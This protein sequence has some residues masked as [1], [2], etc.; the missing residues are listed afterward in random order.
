VAK[1][2][3]GIEQMKAGQTVDMAEAMA[4]LRVHRVPRCHADSIVLTQGQMSPRPTTPDRA[5]PIRVFLGLVPF[6]LLAGACLAAAL[7]PRP[8]PVDTTAGEAIFQQRCAQCHGTGA[9]RKQGPGL[10][11]VVGRRAAAVP[12][13][14]YTSALAASRLTWD[15]ATLD[16][17]LAGPSQLVPGTMMPMAVP[18]AQERRHLIDYLAS[19]P[20]LASVAKTAAAAPSSGRPSAGDYHGDAPGVRRHIRLDDLPPPYATPSAANG[21]SVVDQP[22]G[23]HPSVPPGFAIDVFARDLSHPR[24]LR[25]APDGDLFVAESMAGQ[26][27]VLRTEEGSTKPEQVEVFASGLDR[28]FGIAFFPPGPSPSWIYVANTNAV[29]RFPY[30]RGDLRARGKPQTIVPK[31]T[32]EP[33]GHWTRDIAFSRDGARMFVS[34]G[35]ASN[36]AENLPQLFPTDIAVW[37][38]AHG[39]GAAWDYE[40]NRADVLVFDPEGRGGHTF[41]TGIRNCV[42]LAVNPDTGE[43]WCSVDERDELGDDLVPDYITH[44]REGAFYGWPWFYLGDHED[45]RHINERPDLPG[46]ITVPD[47]LLQA[48]LASLQL[49]F[50]DGAMFPPQYRGNVFAAE[51]GSWNRGSRTGPKIIRV[52]VDKGIATGEYEDFVTGFTVDDASVWARPVGVAVAQDGA[53]LFSEDANGTIWRVSYAGGL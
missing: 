1:E 36:D 20:G 30:Q 25:V 21:P 38:G 33:G 51:H 37:E 28:P 23:A 47:V 2:D 50:Y 6:V 44:V 24:A 45:P 3:E 13:F 10:G 43:P 41:A 35:S 32:R 16:A 15:R 11:T 9:E 34:V 53:L 8:A 48:H 42:G 26:I 52:P 39:L 7:T 14:P 46:K 27:R 18:D 5:S 29:V 40:E 4:E 19:L 49:A 22:P 31:L 17:F 12:G